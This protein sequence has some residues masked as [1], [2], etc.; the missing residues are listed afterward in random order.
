VTDNKHYSDIAN[1]IRA[2][3]G[4]ETTYKPSEMAAA[5]DAIEGTDEIFRQIFEGTITEFNDEKGEF[6]TI[7]AS[8]LAIKMA[9]ESVDFPACTSIGDYALYSCKN[10]T[11]VSFPACTNIGN[12]A[13]DSCY[14]LTS[15][16]FPAC[17]SIGE[18]AFNGC[19]SLTS[20]SFPAC[21]SIGE[22]AFYACRSLT[23]LYLDKTPE[24]C[25]LGE[26]A[27]GE[28]P[29]G[30]LQ[31]NIYVPASLLEEY[32]ASPMWSWAESI[33]VGV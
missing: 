30:N 24:V 22:G 14:G 32:K 16:N 29:L 9:L 17:T 31:G 28:T 33:L 18:G 13:F 1:A 3:N 20:V 12:W 15:A 23:S 27:F 21:T 5:I 19:E 11:S 25:Q 6:E 26:E 10:L 8:A 4:T 7:P 2:K